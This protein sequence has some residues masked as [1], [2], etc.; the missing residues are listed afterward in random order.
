M[1]SPK[2]VLQSPNSGL[3]ETYVVEANQPKT[4]LANARYLVNQVTDNA[5]SLGLQFFGTSKGYT[6][7]NVKISVPTYE[8]L[9]SEDTEAK[10]QSALEGISDIDAKEAKALDELKTPVEKALE[11]IEERNFKYTQKMLSQSQPSNSQQQ[12]Y[13]TCSLSVNMEEV[14]E[15]ANKF[16]NEIMQQKSCAARK[17]VV[18]KPDSYRHIKLTSLTATDDKHHS[19][20]TKVKAQI[21]G[22]NG[23]NAPKLT[24]RAVRS[25]P[26]PNKADTTSV[27]GLKSKL[28]KAHPTYT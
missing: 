28:N 1:E 2:G 4:L 20:E 25:K 7:S 19:M 3:P 13:G 24:S 26:S 22:R 27:P 23:L 15:A 14:T 5:V 17:P 10:S 8:Q 16:F 6:H 11:N 21:V 18:K 12:N 9:L